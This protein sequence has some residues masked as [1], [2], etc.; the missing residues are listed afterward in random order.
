M[1]VKILFILLLVLVSCVKQNR[2]EASGVIARDSV[3]V[4]SKDVDMT[5]VG[6]NTKDQ[7]AV[8]IWKD[9]TTEVFQYRIELLRQWKG[10]PNDYGEMRLKGVRGDSLYIFEGGNSSCN[11]V[12]TLHGLGRVGF[13][14]LTLERNCS[15]DSIDIAPGEFPRLTYKGGRY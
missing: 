11:V 15:D 10:L 2:Q 7:L 9:T 5:F 1:T 4:F 8:L 3:A 6:V 13:D 12:M 14:Y